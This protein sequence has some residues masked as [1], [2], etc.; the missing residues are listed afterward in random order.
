MFSLWSGGP[1]CVRFHHPERCRGQGPLTALDLEAM[2]RLH[3]EDSFFPGSSS[4]VCRARLGI[5]F[6]SDRIG[7]GGVRW[8]ATFSAIMSLEPVNSSSTII[9]CDGNSRRS[10]Y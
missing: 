6:W 8:R 4:I 3:C 1:S 9:H 2:S 10:R 5:I 7:E